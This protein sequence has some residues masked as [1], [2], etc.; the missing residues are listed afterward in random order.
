MQVG[1]KDYPVWIKEMKGKGL[2]VSPPVERGDWVRVRVGEKVNL[3]LL[4]DEATFFFR[5]EVLDLRYLDEEST[6]LISFPQELAKK[7]ITRGGFRLKGEVKVRC[8][9]QRGE[10]LGTSEDISNKGALLAGFRRG[11][12]GKGERFKLEILLPDKEPIPALGQVKRLIDQGENRVAA[13]IEFLVITKKDRER[14]THYLFE[15]DRLQ[16]RAKSCR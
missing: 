9:P 13:A 1:G 11:E 16:R 5:A 4:A 10:V 14:L 8:F 3:C 2:R 15:L 7:A 12:I 6:I